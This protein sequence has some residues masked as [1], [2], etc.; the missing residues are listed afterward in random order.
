MRMRDFLEA[1]GLSSLKIKAGFL[2]GEFTPRDPDRAAT[3]DLY[4][5]LLTRTATQCLGPEVGSEQAVLDSLHDLFPL[6]RSTLKT[7]GP[8]AMPFAKLAI[9]VLNQ[10]PRPF[11]TKWHALALAG[12]FAEPKQCAEF[13]KDLQTLQPHLRNYTR[14]LAALAAVEDLTMLETENRI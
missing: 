12:R 13:R 14:A 8:G 11:T 6:T 5:E 4:V 7:H 2:E 9:P 10:Q 3:W 1:W